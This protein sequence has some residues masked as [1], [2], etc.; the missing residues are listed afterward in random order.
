MAP[1]K[2]KSEKASTE[3]GNSMILQYLKH[4]KLVTATESCPALTFAAVLPQS[5]IF[6]FIHLQ[7]IEISANLHNRVTKPYAVKALKELHEQKLITGKAAGKQIVYHAIQNS[8]DAASPEDIVAM[9]E[10]ISGLREEITRFKADEK[11]LR[12]NLNALCSTSSVSDLR[13]TLAALASEKERLLTRL[14]PLR[15]GNVSTVSTAESLA[16]DKSWKDWSSHANA[17]RKICMNI[18]GE[19][20]EALPEGKTKEELWEELGME[21]DE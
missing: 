11:V 4:Q 7:A 5:T 16:V 3:Q 19:I 1:R 10:E 12:G 13:S 8:N 9:E 20:V 2:E 17:R 18:W 21:D 14:G 6:A 15:S